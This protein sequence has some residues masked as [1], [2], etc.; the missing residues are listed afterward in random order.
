MNLMPCS[1]SSWHSCLCPWWLGSSFKAL[2]K[3]ST[4]SLFFFSRYSSRLLTRFSCCF[5]SSFKKCLSGGV[6]ISY[7]FRYG[8]SVTKSMYFTN[9]GFNLSKIFIVEGAS[10]LNATGSQT[11]PPSGDSGDFTASES[12]AK[13]QFH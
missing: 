3:S 10:C 1:F 12:A 7:L 8:R 6:N 9:S 4:V 13:K 11:D 5:P 2:T